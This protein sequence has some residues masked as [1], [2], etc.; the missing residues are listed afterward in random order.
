MTSL[1]CLGVKVFHDITKM[2]R[3]KVFHDIT[4][5]SRGQGI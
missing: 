4:K 2:S 3:V 1:K 5:M